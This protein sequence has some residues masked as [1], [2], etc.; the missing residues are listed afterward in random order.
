MAEEYYAR[1]ARRPVGGIV[2]G[3]IVLLLLVAGGVWVYRSTRPQP[4]MAARRDI[5]GGVA[6]P[7]AVIVPP[8][9]QA[10]VLPPWRAPVDK[11]EASVGQH[12]SR[13]DVLVRLSMPSVQGG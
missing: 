1:P 10:T 11:V 13:G 12:V 9:A 2:A 3:V 7:G 6:V 4:V 8:S 5:V